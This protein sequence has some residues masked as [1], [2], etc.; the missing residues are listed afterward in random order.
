MTVSLFF[1][2]LFS[3][4][5]LAA[6]GSCNS[7]RCCHCPLRHVKVEARLVLGGLRPLLFYLGVSAPPAP[8]VSEFVNP[9]SHPW[10]QPEVPVCL[11]VGLSQRADRQGS[12]ESSPGQGLR[13]VLQCSER[14]TEPAVVCV[15][16]EVYWFCSRLTL[17]VW[18]ESKSP[19]PSAPPYK[20]GLMW[21]DWLPL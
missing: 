14:A 7:L 20:P 8:V 11:P 18:D 10:E 19:S 16:R 17:L 2:P 12:S 15:S 21:G 4:Q 3:S 6:H 5:G 1:F 13:R 9:T